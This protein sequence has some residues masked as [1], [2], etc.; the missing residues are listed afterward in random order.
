MARLRDTYGLV[1]DN[2][3]K[4]KVQAY[5]INGWSSWS[6]ETASGVTVQTLPVQMQVP[7]EGALTSES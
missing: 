7:T 3:V 2:L 1:L 6:S 5:N 4:V